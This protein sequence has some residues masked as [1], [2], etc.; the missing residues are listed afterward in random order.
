VATPGVFGGNT[1]TLT[2]RLQEHIFRTGLN[3]NF[4]APVVAK[5]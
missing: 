2:S 1:Q 4:N 3:Y 5:Y